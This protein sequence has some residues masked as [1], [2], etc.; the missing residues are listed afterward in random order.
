M[1]APQKLR[2]ERWLSHYK[3]LLLSRRT[4]AQSLALILRVSQCQR[5]ICTTAF[6]TLL[7]PMAN[8]YELISDECETQRNVLYLYK[9]EKPGTCYHKAET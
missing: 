3:L 2:L 8:T 9:Q 5:A 4:R 7:L 1:L 6:T